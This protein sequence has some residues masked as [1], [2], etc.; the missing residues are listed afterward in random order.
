M[1]AIVDLEIPAEQLGLSRPFD[2][3]PDIEIDLAG[4]IGDGLPL[5]HA[6]GPNRAAVERALAAATAV[7]HVDPLTDRGDGRWLFRVSFGA[8]VTRFQR[9][10]NDNQGAI[11]EAIG[12]DRR[13]ACTL[14]FPNRSDLS[15]AHRILGEADIEPT[16]N[17]ISTLDAVDD[18]PSTSPLTRTQYETLLTAHELGYFDVPRQVTLEELSD[19]LGVS[20]Q[21]LSERLRRSH[22][23]LV[24][25][26]LHESTRPTRLTL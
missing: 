1:A 2:R 13:W 15:N 10:V 9:I 11:L 3:E 7:T 14:L 16:I 26:Q 18:G 25:T 21:A 6:S 12:R 4:L 19:E 23:T 17:R 8:P 20:H 22:E 5:V 24:R